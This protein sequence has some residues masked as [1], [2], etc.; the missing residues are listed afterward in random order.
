MRTTLHRRRNAHLV[1][2]QLN[3][4][5]PFLL[6]VLGRHSTVAVNTGWER[7]AE[8]DHLLAVL[9]AVVRDERS[10][11]MDSTAGALAKSDLRDEDTLLDFDTTVLTPGGVST[12]AREGAWTSQTTCA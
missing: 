10:L 5:A 4:L 12:G 6:D 9:T 11:Y 8:T 7:S 1:A 3:A 2:D